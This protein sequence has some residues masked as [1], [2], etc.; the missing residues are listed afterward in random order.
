MTL[1]IDIEKKKLVQSLTSER[2]VSAPTFMQGDSEPLEI[3][4]LETGVDSLFVEKVLVAEKDS[5]RV[6]IARFSGYPKMLTIATGY[7]LN[8][9][10][11]AEVILPLNTKEL[12]IAL[13]EQSQISAYIEVEYSNKDGKVITVL[14]TP[15]IVKNDLIDNAPSVDIQKQFYDKTYID[16]IFAKKADLTAGGNFNSIKMKIKGTNKYGYIILEQDDEGNISPAYLSEVE[17]NA[18]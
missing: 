7:S 4:L 12:E 17:Y 8:N 15:C 10:G 5:L 6:A 16:N 11:G 1:Y 9:N 14:Q 13:Q 18:Q 3:H 2:S